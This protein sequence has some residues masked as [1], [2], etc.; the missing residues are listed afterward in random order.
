[1]QMGFQI[2]F[3]L[4]YIQEGRLEEKDCHQ[5]QS[6]HHWDLEPPAFHEE[7]RCQGCSYQLPVT[8]FQLSSFRE[9]LFNI[10][11][12]VEINQRFSS[13]IVVLLS[14]VV[15]V[16]STGAEAFASIDMSLTLS[17]LVSSSGALFVLEVE[18]TDFD[19]SFR[20]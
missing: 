1:M 7:H 2:S 18:L 3:V 4:D 20:V 13:I 12:F 17:S 9:Q 14:L 16:S 11:I 8:P 19:C 6:C 10:F 5:Q 15:A